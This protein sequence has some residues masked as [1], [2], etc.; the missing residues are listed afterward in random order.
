[1]KAKTKRL[2]ILNFFTVYSDL[3]QM[4]EYSDKRRDI[5]WTHS[6]F[7]ITFIKYFKYDLNTF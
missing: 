6:T 7:N 5:C 2:S 4:R 1:M 3:L